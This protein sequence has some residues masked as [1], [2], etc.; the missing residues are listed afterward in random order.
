[1]FAAVALR[2][3]RRAWRAMRSVRCGMRA[4]RRRRMRGARGSGVL[5]AGAAA[6]VCAMRRLAATARVSAAQVLGGGMRCRRGRLSGAGARGDHTLAVENAGLLRRRHRRIAMVVGGAHG[7]VARSRLLMLL[8]LLRHADVTLLRVMRLLGRW[9]GR[10][11]ARA[12]VERHAVRGGLVGVGFVAN[13]GAP[14]PAA[15]GVAAA[16]LAKPV[17]DASVEA[18]MRTPGA[19]VP[20]VHPAV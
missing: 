12:A 4:A 14:P 20:G 11:A 1:M 16:A 3:P 7:G 5:A 9:G 17:V 6:R 10:Y 2:G 19:A 8:L 15:A 13:K 18:D